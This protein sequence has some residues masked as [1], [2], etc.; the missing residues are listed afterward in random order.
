[1]A[2]TG[3][4]AGRQVAA[5]DARDRAPRRPRRGRRRA[6][7]ERARAANRA[8]P[9]H[10]LAG[11]GDAGRGRPRASASPRAAATGSAPASSS[12]ATPPSRGSTSATLARPHL[13]A[14]AD[15]TG[16]TATLSAPGR[17]RTPSRSTSCRA[18]RRCRASRSSGARASRTRR[19]PA[20]WPCLRRKHPAARAARGP[21]AAD[22]HRPEGA[23]PEIGARAGARMGR[24]RCASARRT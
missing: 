17:S 2:R 22:D 3:T 19:R 23:R 5:V 11:P 14:L 15:T 1:M 4:P 8:Q 21:H 24:A 6:G 9:E 12:S 18:R 16:E 13:E 7:D 10:R 20:R